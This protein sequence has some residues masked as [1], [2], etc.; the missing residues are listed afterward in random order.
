M[1]LARLAS[2]LDVAEAYAVMH[3]AIKGRDPKEPGRQ[4]K[5]QAEAKLAAAMR[6]LFRKQQQR[7]VAY[8][9]TLPRASKDI[10]LPDSLFDDEES[11]ST[12]I[13]LMLRVMRAGVELH[14]A[15]SGV[16]MDYTLVH[17]GAAR[18]AQRLVLDLIKDITVTSKDTVRRVISDY[19][20]TPGMT[21]SDV[22]SKLPFTAERADRIAVTEVTRAY[23][24]AGQAAADEMKKQ[25]PDVKVV[26]TWY[27]N[28]DDIMCDTCRPL[29]NMEVL[30][31]EMFPF[32]EGEQIA[33]PPGHVNCRCFIM[34][35]T[36][37]NG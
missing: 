24:E 16:E 7:V 26:K 29:H 1:A 21:I 2:A 14:A 27:T 22:A 3:G 28:Q 23:A 35:R 10:D 37:I 33:G 20:T 12:I 19:V 31:D 18:A 17:Q 25:F 36:R 15:T 32:G 5:L 13:K 4:Q 6:A 34:V 11:T 9:R 30:A 8:I